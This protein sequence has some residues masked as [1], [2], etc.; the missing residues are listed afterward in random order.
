MIILTPVKIGICGLGTVG[1]GTFNVLKRNINKI[2][3]SAGKKIII[4]QICACKTLFNK[5]NFINKTNNIFDIVYN[6]NIDIVVELIGGCNI[7]LKFVIESIKNGKH[8]VTA[9]KYMIANYGTDIFSLANKKGVIVAFEAAVAGG[10]PIIKSLREGLVANSIKWLIGILNGTLN[11]ILTSMH[12]EY[13]SFKKILLKAKLLGYAEFN[14]ILD[15]EGI[16]VAHKLVILASIAYCIPLKIHQIYIEGISKIISDDIIYADK[17]G[18]KI[19]HLGISIINKYGLELR[20]HPTMIKKTCLISNINDINNA[21]EIM[22]DAVG[23]NFY[24][25]IGAGSEPTA[26]S[27]ISDLINITSYINIKK[28]I[29]FKDYIEKNIKILSMDNIITAYYLRIIASYPKYDLLSK[30]FEIFNVNKISIKS[31]YKKYIISKK[32]INIIIIT[33]LVKELNMNISIN[34]IE[35]LDNVINSVYIRIGYLNNN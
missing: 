23:S 25:G 9:N 20:V 4:E 6:H 28:K 29:S 8:V 13:K 30:I 15:I 11:Y 35:L 17:L 26:S 1:I 14:H 27:I 19:K 5:I 32:L 24:S 31:I 22:G 34:N 10:I 7:A 18:Y 3:Y 33:N 16:D 21:I 2:V 12:N